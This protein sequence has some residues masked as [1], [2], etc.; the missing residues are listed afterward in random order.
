VQNLYIMPNKKYNLCNNNIT[1]IVF[2]TW[3]THTILFYYS[4]LLSSPWNRQRTVA[5]FD[6]DIV[7]FFFSLFIIRIID[8]LRYLIVWYHIVIVDSC[9]V[10]TV[11]LLLLCYYCFDITVLLLLFCYYCFVTTVDAINT[12]SIFII[13]NLNNKIKLSLWNI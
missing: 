3:H 1:Q 10:I 4:K 12:F 2:L 8:F 9:F 13:C 7:L 6:V 11:L 5:T